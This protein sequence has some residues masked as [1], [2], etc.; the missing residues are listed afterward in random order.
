MFSNIITFYINS[1]YRSWGTTDWFTYVIDSLPN[2]IDS[3]AV[4]SITIPKTYYL[5]NENN[6]SFT[7][8]ITNLLSNITDWYTISLDYGNYDETQIYWALQ[9]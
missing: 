7:L 9:D 1:K 2:Y 8:N 4:S 3:C 6:N 5:I